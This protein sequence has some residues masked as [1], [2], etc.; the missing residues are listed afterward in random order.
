MSFEITHIAL[1]VVGYLSIMFGIASA[2]DRGWIPSRI[3]RH[4]I[5]YILSLGV[6]ASTWAYYGVVDLAFQ[7]GYGALAYY[8][9]TGALFLFAPVALAPLAELVRRFRIP[10]LADLLVFRYHS[11]PVGTVAT[12]F[13]VAAVLPLFAMQIQAVA[14]TLRILTMH[15]KAA[16][17]LVSSNINFREILAM[18]F[19]WVLALFTI[20]FGA[21]HDK[22][23]GLVT[24]MAFES[25][26]KLSALMIVGLVAV[27]GV[28]GGMGELDA[29]LAAHPEN[30]ELLH[31]PIQDTSSHTLLLVFIATGVAMPHIFHASVVDVPIARSMRM[32]SWAFPLFLMLMALPIF[33]ILW[34]GLEQAIPLPVQYFTLGVPLILGS[35]TVT[36]I[37]F[38]GGLSA[39]TGALVS[40]TLAITTMIINH[41]ILPLSRLGAKRDLQTQLLRL[42]RLVISAIF[43]AGYL[44]YIILGHNQSLTDLA[45]TAFIETLQFLPGIFAI[46]YWSKGNRFGL[47]TGI[48]AGSLIWVVGLLIPIITGWHAITLPYVGSITLGMDAWHTITL[49]S[50]AVNS[51]AF[52]I[53]SLLTSQ[54]AEELYS[55]SLCAEDELSHPMRMVLDVHSCEEIIER[56][57]QSLGAALADQQVNRAL[58][59]LNLSVSERRPYALR[60]LRDR[61]EANLSSLM[62]NAVASEVI[63]RHLPYRLPETTHTTDIN[64]MEARLGRYRNRLTGM[65]AELNNLRLYH[66]NT[67]EELPMAVC[68]LGHDLE[69]LMWNQAMERLTGIA[70]SDVTGSYLGDVPEPWNQL[71]NDFSDSQLSHL[72]SQ[73]IELAGKPHWVS[74]HKSSITNPTSE[75][76]DGQVILL[77]DVTEVKVL[78]QELI[79]SERLASVG[80]LAAGVAHEIGNPVT[81][82]ACLAQNLKYDVHHSESLETADQILSQTDRISRIVHSLVSFSHA[83]A[84]NEPSHET[85][86]LTTCVDE[87]IQLLS[88]QKDKTQVEFVN[89]VEEDAI[90]EGDSQRLIQVFVNLLANARDASEQDGHVFIESHVS[91]TLDTSSKEGISELAFDG[92]EVTVTDEGEGIDPSHLDQIIEPFFTTKDPGEGTGL[93][94]AMV[95]SII[96]EH[97]GSIDVQS[98]ADPDTQKGARFIIRL[99]SRLNSDAFQSPQENA[100][101]TI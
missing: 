75:S 49:L 37:A 97:G 68:S 18:G 36:L 101:E 13:L 78:E 65:A 67:L 62:G 71:L 38:I 83:G 92:Y 56:L 86:N 51:A 42:R 29:W 84:K 80:R 24:A 82:I 44:F 22:H 77:E 98:P 64:L 27:F 16:N 55:A 57:G 46:A 60:R 43:L 33:P 48:V 99:P 74:L 23:R 32:V 6:F 66:R 31:S 52:V 81:G 9:G 85:V 5:T 47:I 63:N 7:Y 96:S 72:H 20:L 95:Y 41:W 79:H 58:Q 91:Q 69:V 100:T 61:L 12:L 76:A 15:T 45:L 93:G 90:V 70:S 28:F 11:Q 1:L 88:L 17:S 59:E 73:Q 10:S 19:C 2:T 89:L 87:A 30:L 26:V 40:I 8:M 94:L 4:P 50:L 39:A 14:E 3:T 21:N 34:A 54:N 35:P 53:V 25:L